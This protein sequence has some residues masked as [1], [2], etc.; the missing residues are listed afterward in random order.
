MMYFF[1]KDILPIEN[2]NIGILIIFKQAKNAT[3]QFQK[4]LLSNDP[5]EKVGHIYVST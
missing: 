5:Q 4:L 3:A 1:K 2:I